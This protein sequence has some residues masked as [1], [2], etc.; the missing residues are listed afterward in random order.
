MTKSNRSRRIKGASFSDLHVLHRRTPT[1][2]TIRNLNDALPDNQETAALDLLIIAGDVFD[3]L[4]TLANEN[5]WEVKIWVARVLRLC[6]KYGIILRVL[7]GTPS[8]DWKQSNL[9]PV[10]NEIAEIGADIKH[11]KELSIEYIEPLGISVLYVPDEWGPPDNT[12]RQV[13]D[14]LT[15][16]GLTQVDIA[17]MH[18]QFSHQL[19]AHVSA[20]THDAQAYLKIV[21]FFIF[22]G[23]VHTYSQFDRILAQGSHDRFGHGEEEAKGHLR[24][25]IDLDSGEHYATFVENKGAQRYVTVSCN[26]MDLEDTLRQIEEKIKDLPE[27]S[28]VRVEADNDNPVFSNMDSLIRK[29]PMFTWSKL[30]RKEEKEQ[31]EEIEN[32]E[33][34]YTPVSITR[35]NVDG[36]LMARLVKVGLQGNELETANSILKELL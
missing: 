1:T 19:P 12:L 5:I 23:H 26:G 24:F 16:K 6:K 8:H 33:L 30:P 14:L 36:L 11:V 15:A 21:K 7:E 18:G 2:K 28:F 31:K 34:L 3:D 35:D 9:F 13:H 4:A 25:E 29:W 10:I 22:I 27:L 32:E 20:P 17:V